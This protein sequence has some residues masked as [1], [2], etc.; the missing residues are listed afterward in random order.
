MWV[1][2]NE[3][4]FSAETT[5]T[6]D[7]RG[8]EFWLVAVR[9]CFTVDPDGRQTPAAEQTAVQRSPVFAGD[10][11]TSGLVQESDFVLHKDGT[12]VLVTGRAHAPER[13][14]TTHCRVRLKVQDIDK[15]L[16]V[17]GERRLSWGALGLSIAKPRPFIAM[18]LAWER[19]Y[20]GWDRKGDKDEWEPANPAGV[21]FA[22]DPSHLHESAAPNVEYP[23]APYRGPRSGRPAAFGPVA[24]HWQPRVKYAGT[25]DQ[26]WRASRDPLVPEDFDR[27]YFRCA[28]ADQQ[29]Q[30]PLVGYE[31]VELWGFT[32]EGRLGF[33]LP[34]IKLDI[35]TTFKRH[36]DVEQQ[37]SIHTLWLMPELR[38][39][40]IVYL[41]A[42][43][44]PPGREEKLAG[45]TIRIKPRVGVPAAIQR[46]GV[47]SGVKDGGP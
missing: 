38:R 43:E 13:R 34:R 30:R 25:Y 26:R 46:T 24:Q 37:P 27:R 22:A 39:F 9:A 6:R 15:T 4:P 40:E 3:T 19:T 5:W 21:G 45:T 28:P 36:G 12:D 42:L 17:V 44:V 20:G 16:D 18:P 35:I 31:E 23:D 29:T 2:R 33:L 14:P 32:P 47:W 10:P 41:A 8:A 7:E 11:G 1:L